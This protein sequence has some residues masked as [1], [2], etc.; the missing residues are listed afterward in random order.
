MTKTR[1]R[2]PFSLAAW[3][4][5]LASSVPAAAQD[6]SPWSVGVSAERAGVAIGGTDQSWDTD[7]LQVSWSRPADGGWFLSVD[8]LARNGITDLSFSTRAYRRLG[9][10]T[11]LVGGGGTPDAQFFYRGFAE[12]ELSRRV[13]GTLVASGGYRFLSFPST[14]IHQLQ[15]ALTWYHPR[16]EVAGRLFVTRNGAEGRTTHA[17]LART[18]YRV[19]PRLEMGG[20]FAFGDRIFD[21]STLQTGL[22]RARVGFATARIGVTAHDALELGATMAGEHPAFRYRSVTVGYRRTF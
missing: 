6:S 1:R 12:S 15:P 20:G 5:L 2:L 4:C 10:W 17:F 18:R 16:G 3:L 21:V 8:R 11:I 22:A 13:A 7:R 14:G 9:D 19:G